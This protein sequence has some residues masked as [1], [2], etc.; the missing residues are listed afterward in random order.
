MSTL[1]NSSLKRPLSKLRRD[2][3]FLNLL[4]GIYENQQ[5]NADGMH[6]LNL[7]QNK[8]RS[9]HLHFLGYGRV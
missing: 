7:G 8:S 1:Q 4:K 2:E 9:H 6:P 5:I 3:I